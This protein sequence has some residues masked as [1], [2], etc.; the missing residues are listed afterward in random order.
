MSELLSNFSDEQRDF[1]MARHAIIAPHLN[2]HVPLSRVAADHAISESTLEKWV[3]DFRRNGLAGLIRKERK[4]KGVRRTVHPELQ[5]IIEGLALLGRPITAIQG[6]AERVAKQRGWIVPEYITVWRVA[7]AIDPAM[8]CLAREGSAAYM[9]KYDL[10][11]HRDATGSNEIWQADHAWLPIWLQNDKGEP[12]QPLLTAIEDDHS[13]AIPGFYLAFG[14][15][16]SMNTALAMHMAVSRKFD[17]RYRICGY[18]D[19]FYS[20]HGSDFISEHIRQVLLHVNS[21]HIFSFPG[22][23]RGRGRVERFFRSV[24]QL[25]LSELENY[26]PNTEPPTAPLLPL[27][28]FREAF[29][30]WLVGRYHFRKHGTTRQA[31][32]ERWE[33]GGFLPRMPDRPEELD[34]LLLTIAES[35]RVQPDG[36]HFSGRTYTDVTLAAY[37]KEDVT[38]RYHPWDA[39]EIHVYHRGQFLCR[40][41]D[42]ELAGQTISFKELIRARRHRKKE[43]RQA[44]EER[45]KAAEVALALRRPSVDVD[46]SPPQPKSDSAPAPFLKRFRND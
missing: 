15:P 10:L 5:P 39:A 37:V 23:P 18:P 24:A 46:E 45:T 41:I 19:I 34:L 31:P 26:C 44:I 11:Y 9:N 8:M 22:V 42:T 16:S 20:D 29:R 7:K 30:E 38:I 6:L 4:D 36:I 21:E 2:D 13:R 28:A 35:R 3:A 14:A 33:A 1:A 25:F 40:A 17:P 43:L 27:A 12:E 32:I